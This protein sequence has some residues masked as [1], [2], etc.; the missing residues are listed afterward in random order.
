MKAKTNYKEQYEKRLRY[1]TAF[2]KTNYKQISIS[3]KYNTNEKD[4]EAYEWLQAQANKTEYLVNLI[5]E[6][7]KRREE[8]KD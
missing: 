2:I 5:L 4:R 7:K 1:N 8:N 6:D 3:F